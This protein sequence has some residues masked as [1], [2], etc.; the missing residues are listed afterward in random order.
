MKRIHAILIM[1]MLVLGGTVE[2]K[3]DDPYNYGS[4]IEGV[5]AVVKSKA[6]VPITALETSKMALTLGTN[7]AVVT[8]LISAKQICPP[9]KWSLPDL[10]EEV[11]ATFGRD[12]PKLLKENGA[13]A[14]YVLVSSKWDCKK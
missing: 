11:L 8:A 5:D 6:G 14:V 7:N 3:A 12:N 4:Y 10:A 13:S 1:A 2:A 9:E